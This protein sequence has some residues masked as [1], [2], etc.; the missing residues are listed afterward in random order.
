MSANF[1]K[2]RSGINFGG[3]ASDPSDGANGDIYYN[4]ATNKFRGYQNG[5]WIDLIGGGGGGSGTVTTV[6]VTSANGVSG[7]VANATTTP[8]ITLTLGNITPTT[9]AATGT[10]TGSNLSGTNTGDQT[11]TL[12]GDVSGSGNGSFA[13]TIAS[14]AVTN[15]KL[16]QM[17]AHTF[18][19]NNTGSPANALDL[20]ATQLTAELDL[21][22]SALKGLVPL[23]GGGTTNFLRADG[24]W[25]APPTELS[26]FASFTGLLVPTTSGMRWRPRKTVTLTNVL[27]TVGTAPSIPLVIDIKKNGSSILG[28]VYPTVL[29]GQLDSANFPINVSV[30]STDVITVNITS[31]NGQ[32]L[33]VRIDYN[34]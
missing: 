9:V 25:A 1:M 5:A 19:G 31:G 18:K 10:V 23:S 26:I 22:T 15:A 13:A 21:F 30:L 17:A 7:S 27:M 6:S 33:S 3:L 14:N 4:T 34:Y 2:V 32:D 12:T 8:A 28:G 16:A 11:I 29:S 24:T 20:T